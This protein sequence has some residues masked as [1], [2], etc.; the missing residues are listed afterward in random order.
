[1]IKSDY[2][3]LTILAAYALFIWLQDLN[4]ISSL[5]DTLP[6]LLALPVFIWIGWPWDFDLNSRPF[7]FQALFLA[8]LG[9]IA[10]LLVNSIALLSFSWT[11]ALWGWLSTRLPSER[12]KAT[13]RLLIL[14][15]MAFPWLI[16]EGDIIGWWFRLSGAWT[17]EL[18]FTTIGY[19]VIHEGTLIM[20]D[21]LPVG[22]DAA[23][24]G[25]NA[26]QSMLIAGSVIAVL[27][28]GDRSGFWLGILFLF[29]L[30]WVANTLRIISICLLGLLISPDYAQGVF[31]TWGGWLV[32]VIMFC[33]SW[34]FLGLMRAGFKSPLVEHEVYQ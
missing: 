32:L 25:L 18:F 2:S 6:I 12:L 4:W 29:L 34:F 17:A 33:L 19:N 11:M 8:L 21:N 15:F 1:M 7:P 23:C 27:Q 22:I 9:F 20:I 3:I 16:L 24:S 26:L 28:L 10:G 5:E 31:H 30:A 14:P 13:K